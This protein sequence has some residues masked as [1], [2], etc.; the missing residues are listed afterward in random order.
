MAKVKEPAAQAVGRA[1]AAISRTKWKGEQLATQLAKKQAV[2]S[3]P[4]SSA[5]QPWQ[6]RPVSALLAN[7]SAEGALLP[8]NRRESAD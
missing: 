5:R 1:R 2:R 8:I 7:E 3:R 4:L 6:L